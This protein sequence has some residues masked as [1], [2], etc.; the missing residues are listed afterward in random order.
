MR[1]MND[2]S[3]R[4][5][6]SCLMAV[7]LIAGLATVLSGCGSMAY[8]E[9][10]EQSASQSETQDSIRMSLP[11]GVNE[12]YYDEDY[13][14][15]A[16]L[17]SLP[18]SAARKIIQEVS[19]YLGVGDISAAMDSITGICRD[20]KG[21]VVNS[22]ISRGD[23]WSNGEIVVKIP[24]DQLDEALKK[25]MA[26]GEVKDKSVA[27]HDVTEEYYDSEARLKVLQ[28][29]EERLLGLM[30]RATTIEEIIKVEN[31]FS[32]VRSQIE[33][34]QGRLQYLDNATS[35]STVSINLTQ[36][37]AGAVEVPSGTLGKAGQAFIDSVNG[38][39]DFLSGALV[40]LVGFL[41]WAVLL[42]LLFIVLRIIKRKSNFS[43]RRNKKKGNPPPEQG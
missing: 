28:K 7:L 16:P 36:V 21:Y 2:V 6:L 40:W 24:G 32:N 42:F 11:S 14:S 37:K 12:I 8:V 25:M 1:R 5:W 18:S 43:L 15:S 9:K 33:V 19:L 23:D 22:R 17:D 13:G 39:I 31:E 35:Y 20:H 26:L 38:V 29:K 30:D 27:T 41:P 34:L 10:A 3:A 4:R